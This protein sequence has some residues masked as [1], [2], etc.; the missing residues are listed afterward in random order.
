MASSDAVEIETMKG[1][2]KV[3]AERMKAFSH[4]TA[5]V[6]VTRNANVAAVLELRTEL[7][8]AAAEDGISPTI[9][10]II[11][12]CISRVLGNFPE[13]NAVLDAEG[14]IERHRDVHLGFAVDAH[15]SPLV[16]VIH[17][18]NWLSLDDLSRISKELKGRAQTGKITA[19][20]LRGGTFTVSTLGAAGVHWFTP[21]L[22]TPEVGILGIG[23]AH[24]PYPGAP[25][26]LPL[27]LTF[28]RN[29]S[30]E[31]SASN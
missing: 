8:E 20:E 1:A 30:P 28:D 2:R 29:A 31:P 10:E 22:N 5:Q 4:E 16:P 17:N 19:D 12:F 6:T 7:K 24:V 18:A 27:S 25:P 21:T 15:R 14:R 13:I 9:N 26:Q 11:M 3:V 23:S